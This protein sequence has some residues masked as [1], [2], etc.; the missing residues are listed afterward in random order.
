MCSSDLHLSAVVGCN[1]LVALESEAKRLMDEATGGE[2]GLDHLG[3]LLQTTMKNLLESG[4]PAQALSGPVA[5]G[6]VGTVRSHL[7]L[8]ERESPRLAQAY[9]ALSL[10]A[11]TLAAPRLDDEQVRC[12]KDLLADGAAGGGGAAGG[13][14]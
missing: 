7:R 5:R 6:D 10:E 4:Q 9:R 13:A 1:L 14:R 11:L 8:M 3:P 12:L 2:D